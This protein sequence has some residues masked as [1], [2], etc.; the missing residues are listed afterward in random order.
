VPEAHRAA[1][2]YVGWGCDT[3]TADLRVGR[4]GL[5]LYA[6]AGISHVSFDSRAAAA[7]YLGAG[8]A[9]AEPVRLALFRQG[10][11]VNAAAVR[12]GIRLQF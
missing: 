1:H 11:S 8:P 2:D 4:G 7:W 12:V 9:S 10:G 6:G 5:L 3:A